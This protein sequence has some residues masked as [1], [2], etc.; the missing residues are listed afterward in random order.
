MA[1]DAAFADRFVLV[2]ERTALRG[3]TLH[4]GVIHAQKRDPATDDRLLQAGAAAFNCLSLV[5]IV[6]IR[7]THFAFHHRMVMRKLKLCPERG[8]TL[9][10][11]FGRF[12]RIDDRVSSA[13]ALYV[14]TSRP[15]A[16][17]ATHVLGVL[18]FC[19]QTRMRRRPEIA[20]LVFVAGSAL[21]RPDKLRSWNTGRRENGPIRL[22]RAARKQNDGE[23][24]CSPDRPQQFFAFTVEPSS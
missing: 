1:N 6:T 5:R 18:A 20:D 2:N 12:A 21:F 17:L 16:R 23:R 10:T 14:Q 22:E 19:L 8:V 11:G 13:A 3:V 15:V 4:A 7:T 24:G 9:K